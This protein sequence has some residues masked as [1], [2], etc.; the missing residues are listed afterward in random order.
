MQS[1]SGRDRSSS[2]SGLP[3]HPPHS[4]PRR[5]ASAWFA[6]KDRRTLWQQSANAPGIVGALATGFLRPGFKVKLF[7]AALRRC[8]MYRRLGQSQKNHQSS[9]SRLRLFAHKLTG[10]SMNIQQIGTAMG[11]LDLGLAVEL[12]NRGQGSGAPSR[13]STT[14]L[15]IGETIHSAPCA[16]TLNDI[17]QSAEFT[18]DTFYADMDL[19]APKRN[20]FFPGR[21]AH[22]YLLLFLAAGFLVEPGAGR[23]LANSG[24]DGLR[25]IKPVEVGDSIRVR[26]AVKEETQ[27]ADEFG[28]V[29]RQVSLNQHNDELVGECGLLTMVAY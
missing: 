15:T 26:L 22:G 13:A 21:V 10:W 1:R 14:D 8:R 27:R 4:G 17:G 29:R 7:V 6:A 18:D 28:E 2:G 3:Y 19:E 12:A 5:P 9:W 11:Y 24:L 25:F 16:V 23:A 20:P